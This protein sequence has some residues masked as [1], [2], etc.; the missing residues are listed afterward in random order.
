LGISEVDFMAME[1]DNFDLERFIKAQENSFETA[2]QEIKNGCKR[3]HWMWFI[4]PQIR[5][6]G[7]SAMAE[8]Y[9]ICG[10]DEAK[11]YFAEP[12]LGTRL[13]QISEALLELPN[14]NATE[15]FGSPDDMKLKSCMTLFA[16]ADSTSSVFQFVLDKYFAGQRDDKTLNLLR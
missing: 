12:T 5:G 1:N 15:I 2:L 9:G 3:S 10:I 14:N 7:R 16:A 6:L 4:F 11:A 13:I 8:R